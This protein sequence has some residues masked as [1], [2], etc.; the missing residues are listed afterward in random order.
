MANDSFTETTSTG[1]FS[2]IGNSIKG[3]LFG[4]LLIVV[5]VPLLFINEGRA[6]KTRKTLDEGAKSF[7]TIQS[8]AVDS[9]QDGKLVYLT[10]PASA[11]TP[12]RDE[13]LGIEATALRMKR[14]VE[15]F[16]WKENSTTE[17]KKKLGGGEESTTT[18]SYEKEWSDK[19]IDSSKFKKPDGHTNP[20]A[21]IAS[22]EWTASP[23]SLGAYVLSPGLAGRIDNFTE[24][25][26]SAETEIPEVISGKKLTPSDGGFYLGR[27]PAN[28]EVGDSRITYA[29]ALPGEVS[30]VSK[31][32]GNSFEPFMAKAGGSIE[33]LATGKQSAD[34]MFVSAQETN[35][36][37]TWLLRGLGVLLMFIG[38]SMLF[39]PLSVIADVLPIAGNIVGVGTNIVA[40]FLAIPISLV[41]IAIAWIFYRPLIGIPLIVLAVA[42]FVF[43][44]RKLMSQRKRQAGLAPS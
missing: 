18:Y 1:W 15:I 7:V 34:S 8:E 37:V 38:F 23:I 27:N 12:L 39:R 24:L 36:I 25:E 6:V 32:M 28:P 26:P 4:L 20:Q 35:K 2:R 31:L 10:G 41:V 14:N 13:K 22:K 43:L 3:I 5:S 33:M 11:S 9:A 29:V 42:G 21:L 30:I 17:T 44:I 19:R 16:Q 40:F